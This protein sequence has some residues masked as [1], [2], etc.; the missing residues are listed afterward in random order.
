LPFSYVV[1]KDRK[2]VI[3]TG[4]GRVT[5]EEIRFRQDQTQTDPEFD[6]D[7][8]QI[9]DLRAATAIDGSIDEFKVLASRK[10]FSPQSRRAFLASSPAVFGMGRLWEAQTEISQNTS[11]IRVF[12]DVASAMEWLGMKDA[13]GL[14]PR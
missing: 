1:Y 3:S 6:P 7:F 8:N 9:V 4:T 12:Y 5:C 11:H 2:L 13:A 10:V 14:L